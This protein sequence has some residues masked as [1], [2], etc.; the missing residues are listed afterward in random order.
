M[1]F[2]TPI[3]KLLPKRDI[4]FRDDPTSR[5]RYKKR[6]RE[7]RR[8]CQPKHLC[9]YALL[10][11]DNGLFYVG[12][13]VDPEERLERHISNCKHEHSKAANYLFSL[14]H[15]GSRPIMVLLEWT[16][17]KAREDVWI[18]YFK[19]VLTIPLKNTFGGYL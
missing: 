16:D 10:D 18:Q 9:V 11:P 17:D 3:E 1:L 7:K 6:L 15:R 13:T 14:L 4:L 5:M 12:V 2:S 8:L 19:E